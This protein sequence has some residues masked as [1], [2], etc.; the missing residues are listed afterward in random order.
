MKDSTPTPRQV[1]VA[2][3]VATRQV[4]HQS[5]PHVLVVSSRKHKGKFV[6]PKGGIEQDELAQEAAE[7]EAWEEA[8]LILGQAMHLDHVATLADSKPHQSSPTQ[9]STHSDFVTST[10]YHVELFVVQDIETSLASDWPEANQR[11]RQ[12]ITGWQQLKDVC[13]WGRRQDV[14]TQAIDMVK[15]RL[16]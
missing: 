13:C 3:I 1:A 16:Q 6:L 11:Q 8:G 15:S 2:F 9:D 10:M 12:W 7:R 5:T 4:H 14:M